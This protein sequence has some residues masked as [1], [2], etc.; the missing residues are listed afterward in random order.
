VLVTETEFVPPVA[1][2]DW[3]DGERVGGT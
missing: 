1:G 3:L 2:R